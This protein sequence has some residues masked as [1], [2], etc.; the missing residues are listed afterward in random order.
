[1]DAS[2][3][4]FAAFL[5]Q[6]RPTPRELA[7][8]RAVARVVA[9]ALRRH[10]RPSAPG[11]LRDDHLVAGSVG[12]RTAIRPLPAVDLYYL[13][14]GAPCGG[15]L[16]PMATMLDEASAALAAAGLPFHA[17]DGWR[18][19]ITAEGVTVA[20]I[21]CISR[22]GGFLIPGPGG[23]R[24]SNPTAEAAALRIADGVCAGRLGD[25]LTLLKAWRLTVA[26]APPPFALEV[27]AR[28]FAGDFPA[29]TSLPRWLA[30]FMVWARRATPA[31]FSLPGRVG[32]LDVDAGWHGQAEA[33]YW[34]LI[35]A[36][37]RAAAGDMAE[38]AAEWRRLFGPGFPLLTEGEA[39]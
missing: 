16:P 12:K 33:A 19:G 11:D 36:E 5:R 35:L 6:L 18:I 39:V 2:A 37:R 8:A 1:M 21:P 25:L 29:A 22:G 28:E 20:A 15:D 10:F 4:A 27:L 38:A 14:P 3:P 26:T 31:A 7:L 17:L 24:P 32:R 9:T 13:L 34:R 30:D 23:W